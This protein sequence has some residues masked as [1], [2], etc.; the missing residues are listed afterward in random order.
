MKKFLSSRIIS[1]II[2]ALV[3]VSAYFINVEVQSYWGRQTLAKAAL[4]NLPLAEAL[5]KAKAE[6]KFILVDVSAIWCPTCRRLDNNVFADAKVKQTINEKFVFSR[7]EYESAEGT[8][9]LE[10]HNAAGF[11]NLWLLDGNGNVVK[12]LP[13]TFNPSEFLSQLP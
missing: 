7:L 1:I 10:K 13:V 6:N 11:P 4:T 9:F 5:T 8:A 12:H 2:F 3:A